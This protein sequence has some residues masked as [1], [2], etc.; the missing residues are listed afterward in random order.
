MKALQTR[1]QVGGS[2]DRRVGES[3][4]KCRVVAVGGE[5]RS[6]L[7]VTRRLDPTADVARADIVAH[8]RR[9]AGP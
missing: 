2:R 9:H 1:S 6:L 5:E 3:R 7:L 8:E 4:L